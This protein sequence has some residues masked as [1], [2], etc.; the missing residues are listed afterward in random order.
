MQ[1]R[2]T[3]NPVQNNQMLVSFGGIAAI[4]VYF[5]RRI[6]S[7]HVAFGDNMLLTC[8]VLSYYVRTFKTKE[9]KSPCPLYRSSVEIV[10]Y[11]WKHLYV[12]DQGCHCVIFQFIA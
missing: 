5:V 9:K 2:I 3:T 8:M 6:R 4:S 7:T 1:M 12:V 10:V 11:L